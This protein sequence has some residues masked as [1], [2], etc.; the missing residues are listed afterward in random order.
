MTRKVHPNAAAAVS[1]ADHHHDH[2]QLYSKPCADSGSVALTVWKKSLLLNCDGFTVFDSKGNLVF[3]V[4]NYLASGKGEIFLMDAS[5]KSL[6]TIRRKRLS[7]AENWLVFEGEEAV[8]PRFS[9]RKIVNIL[10]STSIA[11]VSAISICGDHDGINGNKYSRMA[12]VK[13]VKYEIEGS[14]SRRCC[15]VYDDKRRCV[16]EI[17]RKEAVGQ[18][19]FGAD[20]FRLILHEPGLIDSAVAMA[21]VIILDQMFG[22][23]F[24][25]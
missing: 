1:S 9:V 23:S 8:N 25:F 3:R 18:V 4:D 15:A 20:V 14:Y 13:K 22:S 12:S 5:G 21:L 24:H 19:V 6:L 16:A 17:K 2:H 10:N 7:L 11:Q